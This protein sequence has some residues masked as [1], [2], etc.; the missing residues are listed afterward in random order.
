MVDSRV[1]TLEFPQLVRLIDERSTAFVAAVA[2]AP[3]VDVPVPTCPGWTL[4][5]LAQHLGMGRRI[6]EQL[7]DWDPSA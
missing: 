1:M 6:F 2:S 3:S 7:I 4:F 5:D